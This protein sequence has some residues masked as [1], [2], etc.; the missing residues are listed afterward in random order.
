[1]VCVISW[2][3]LL[4]LIILIILSVQSNPNTEDRS[5]TLDLPKMIGRKCQVELKENSTSPISLPNEGI[6]LDVDEEWLLMDC[7]AFQGT[8][9]KLFRIS[10]IKSVK[11][12]E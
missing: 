7:E 12:I 10:E 6:L 1:M 4:I 8:V 11:V 5:W 2:P 9:R 3:I